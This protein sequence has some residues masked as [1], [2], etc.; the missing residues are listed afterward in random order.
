MAELPTGT[1]TFLFTDIEGSTR[2]LQ[3]LGDGYAA[4][5][6]EHR[7]ALRDAWARHDGVEVDTQGDAF[8]VAFARASDA[9]A[10]AAD[11]QRALAEG[12]VRV[13]MNRRSPGCPDCGGWTRPPDPRLALDPRARRRR[14]A[15]RSRRPPAQRPNCAGADLPAR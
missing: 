2:L 5:L 6:A 11:A 9:V 14:G 12:L 1:V 7:R 13:R 8:F 15:P 3:E 10:A 4:V